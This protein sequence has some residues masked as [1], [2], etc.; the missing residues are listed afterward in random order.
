MISASAVI[1]VAAIA[2]RGGTAGATGRHRRSWSETMRVPTCRLRLHLLHQP[3]PLDHVGE[4][5][6]ILDIGGDGELPARLH[7]LHHQRLHP[8]RAP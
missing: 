6:I 8:A 5:G 7:A 1:D 2:I 3:R 4:A